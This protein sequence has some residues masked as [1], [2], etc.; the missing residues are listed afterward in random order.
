[1]EE[2]EKKANGQI[3]N[4]IGNNGG[5]IITSRSL[6]RLNNFNLVTENFVAV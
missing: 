2:K 6:A 5:K 4:N 3:E 1:M